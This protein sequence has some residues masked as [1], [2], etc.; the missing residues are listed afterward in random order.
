MK[1]QIALADFVDAEHERRAREL[2][3]ALHPVEQA[4]Y[5][6][7]Q[8]ARR[9]QVWLAGRE[10]LLA[11]LA[12]Q[13][14]RVDAAALH[15]DARGAVRYGGGSVRIS[16]S[17]SGNLL[18]A[19]LASVPVGVDVEQSRPRACIRQAGRLFTRAEVRYLQALEPAAIQTG[20]YTLWTLKE[21]FAKAAGIS[22]WEALQGAEFD[23]HAR[24]VR[25]SPPADWNCV[26]V[27]TAHGWHL[28][29]VVQGADY[30]V[31]LE[32]RRRSVAGAWL[33]ENLLESTTL[34]NAESTPCVPAQVG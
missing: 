28:A 25:A 26:H 22:L 4:R 2:L 14:P 24:C 23:L 18:V 16:L 1:V 19:A 12:R 20:F 9:R 3:P 11:A 29:V 33:V 31:Q 21:A 13:L 7:F 34:R 30:A 15:S 8:H 5:R 17:H 32:C 27:R 10:L 6:A